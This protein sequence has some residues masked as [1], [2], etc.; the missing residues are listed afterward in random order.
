MQ[1]HLTFVISCRDYWFRLSSELDVA[2]DGWAYKES[3]NERHHAICV[4]HW[5]CGWAVHVES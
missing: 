3:Y 4:L 1:V 2:N 5:Q